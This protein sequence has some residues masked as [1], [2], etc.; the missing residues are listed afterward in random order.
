AAHGLGVLAVTPGVFAVVSGVR[1]V[2]RRGPS[3]ESRGD[4]GD[5]QLEEVIVQT[6]RYALHSEFS[7]EETLLT[8]DDIQSLP[9]LGEEPLRAVQRLP[10]VATNGV[11]SISA[12]RGGEPNETAI[13]LD[14]LRLYEPF[15]LKHFLT[16][17]SLLDSR[18]VQSIQ[19]Y[20]GGFPVIHGDR[21]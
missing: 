21:M 2:E 1:K 4:P 19:V 12:V 18:L 9:S 10:G 6:S 13:V 14:G 15:H 16:P 8:H 20:A 7:V 17:I 5:A 11:S 3:G